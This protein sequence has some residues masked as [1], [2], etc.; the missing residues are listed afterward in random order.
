MIKNFSMLAV[1]IAVALFMTPFFLS[2]QAQAQDI[3]LA[4]GERAFNKCKACHTLDE[5]G[6]HRVGPNLHGFIGREAAT[7]PGFPRY[8]KAMKDSGIVWDDATLDAYLENP[9]KAVRGTN[10]AFVGVRKAAERA[11]LIAYLKEAT[12]PKSE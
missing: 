12:A 11:N 4:A 8:S 1:T 6:R 9:R 5:G 2:S 10:M 7:A 3:D